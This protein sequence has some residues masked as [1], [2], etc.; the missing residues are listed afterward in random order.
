MIITRT[1]YRVSFF[2]GGTDYPV[3]FNNHGGAVLTTAISHYCYISGRILPPFFNHKYLISWSKIEK[4]NIVDEIKNGEISMIINTP[5][6]AQSRYDEQKIGMSA[7][8]HNVPVLTTIPGSQAAIR[9]IRIM[10]TGKL[11][12]LSLQEIFN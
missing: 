3:W 10:K 4:P 6:G 12:H 5:L 8:R 2:G 11:N 9:G 7:I 1:P